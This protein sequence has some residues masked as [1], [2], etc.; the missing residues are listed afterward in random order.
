MLFTRR[1]MRAFTPHA[2]SW[3]LFQPQPK[4]FPSL[5]S[6][7]RPICIS[8]LALAAPL[9]PMGD[10]RLLGCQAAE[11]S[12]MG[13]MTTYVPSGTGQGQKER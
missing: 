13:G 12:E 1:H 11:P 2:S 5:I 10:N 3:T 9:G 6:L 7:L 8:A 4:L